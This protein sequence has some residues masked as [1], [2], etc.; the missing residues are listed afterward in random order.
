MTETNTNKRNMPTIVVS[1][2]EA[3][4]STL[5]HGEASDVS[6]ESIDVLEKAY[7][8]ASDIRQRDAR[9]ADGVS[10]RS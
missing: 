10:P 7:R 6:E 8:W 3:R 5:R 4:C 1:E 2:A 9:S